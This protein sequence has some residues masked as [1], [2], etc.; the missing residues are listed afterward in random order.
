MRELKCSR[1]G[2]LLGAV[3]AL[4]A[5]IA[6]ATEIQDLVRIK[7]HERNILTGLGIVIGLDGTGDRGSDSL[8]AARPMARL[9]TNLGGGVAD[10]A[11]LA[12]GDA[13]AVVQV[14][15]VIPPVGAREGD[16][17]DV[18]VDSLFNAKS[19]EGG[20]L[21]PSLLRLPLPDS[22]D[23]PPLA[24]AQGRV[25]IEGDN[26]RAGVVRQGG[27]LFEYPDLNFR[28]NV[29]SPDGRMTL[30]LHDRYASHAVATVIAEAINDTFVPDGYPE[31]AFVEDAKNVRI[32]L[33]PAERPNP[34]NFIATVMTIQIDPSLI[35]TPARVVVNEDVGSIVIT[36]NVQISPVAITHDGLSITTITPTPI[37]TTDD[38]VLQ[39]SNWATLD[40]TRQTSRS[41]ARLEDLVRA[42]D[43]LKI[44][45]KDRI[46][47]LY[48]LRDAGV[49]HA[50]IIKQ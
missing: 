38:P 36:G 28:T 18:S 49:L 15:M 20:R 50:E 16:E 14:T 35:R 5:G 25:I 4:S 1:I 3:F 31:I 42:F 27:Q 9:L 39:T 41:S 2:A 6:G 22:A 21:V 37:P 47:I 12:D 45:A 32:L 33:P 8:I 24:M 29:L 48:Q 43:Q 7:G 44:P 19:L 11:E 46:A 30:V 26:P 34:A 40:V 17:I 13:F 10:L 23:L